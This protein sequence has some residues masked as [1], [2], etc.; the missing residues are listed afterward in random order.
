M[1]ILFDVV[2]TMG[3][4]LLALSGGILVNGSI[5]FDLSLTAL[6]CVDP[7]LFVLRESL[8]ASSCGRTRLLW[9][10]WCRQSRTGFEC[11]HPQVFNAI[12]VP[13]T[14]T[15]HFLREDGHEF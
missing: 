5:L 13:T 10:L 2:I 1:L 4:I 11:W 15:F 8:R 12:L 6:K 7:R 3:I 9:W 14:D